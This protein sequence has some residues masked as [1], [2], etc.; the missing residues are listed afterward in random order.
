MKIL[1]LILTLLGAGLGLAWYVNTVRLGVLNTLEVRRYLL[2]QFF[3]EFD[4]FFF[5]E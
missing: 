2:C 3:E 5:R 4:D 1:T